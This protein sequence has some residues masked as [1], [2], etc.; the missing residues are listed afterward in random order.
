MVA[1]LFD[2]RSTSTAALKASAAPFAKAFHKSRRKFFV[3]KEM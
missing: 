2:R 1:C 3:P